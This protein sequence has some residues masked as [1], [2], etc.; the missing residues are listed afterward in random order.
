MS[1]KVSVEKKWEQQKEM[2]RE[3]GF[4]SLIRSRDFGMWV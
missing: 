1:K 4:Y 3:R 2:E